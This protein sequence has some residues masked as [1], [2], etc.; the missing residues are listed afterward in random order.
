MSRFSEVTA[1]L[2]VIRPK[3]LRER[4]FPK[5]CLPARPGVRG[6]RRQGTS[7]PRTEVTRRE[8][9][10][11]PLA[12]VTGNLRRPRPIFA[13]LA[14]CSRSNTGNYPPCSRSAVPLKPGAR[15]PPQRVP[16]RRSC[17][18]LICYSAACNPDDRAEQAY[19]EHTGSEP[20]LEWRTKD[21]QKGG[22]GV[23]VGGGGV[24]GVEVSWK[25]CCSAIEE[26]WNVEKGEAL[27]VRSGPKMG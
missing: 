3:R 24:G 27:H 11:R 5:V 21:S 26:P 6:R 19:S 17:Q 4:S 9:L 25:Q 16:R 10:L 15:I 8:P 20:S 12:G 14:Y 22:V 1:H 18:S 13:P 2:G 7:S 23:G